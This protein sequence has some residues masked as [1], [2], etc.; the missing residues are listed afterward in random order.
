MWL[1]ATESIFKDE[2]DPTVICGWAAFHAQAIEEPVIPI[3]S[4]V[5][6]V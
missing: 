6:N 3:E 1:K 4:S 2:T 5:L